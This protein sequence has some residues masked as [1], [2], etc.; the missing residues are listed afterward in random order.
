MK[1][2]ILALIVFAG[3]YL[4]CNTPSSKKESPSNTAGTDQPVKQPSKDC[5]AYTS[6]KDTV[7]MEI[8]TSANKV[9]GTLT[10]KLFEK[11]Q[12]IG[13]IE[14]TMSG[15]TLFATYNFI[16]EGV[17][18]VREVAFIRKGNDFIEGFGEVEEMDGKMIFKN[19]GALNYGSSI[20]LHQVACGE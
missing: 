20:V 15:D 7:L 5:Y 12:N 11:D 17:E 6:G 9:S 3:M 1:F 19:K 13:R 4:S 8:S 2:A 16:S 10:Y 14:G 18:S